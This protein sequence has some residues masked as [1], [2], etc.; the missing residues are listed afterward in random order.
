MALR[1]KPKWI[2]PVYITMAQI[3]Q[4]IVGISVCL[5]SYYYKK[6]HTGTC[7]VTD[8]NLIAGAVMY[9]SYAFLFIKFALDRFLPKSMRFGTGMEKTPK[10]KKIE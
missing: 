3:T 5:A 10:A 7:S 9:G 6:N 2:N 8:D 4:M 1:M